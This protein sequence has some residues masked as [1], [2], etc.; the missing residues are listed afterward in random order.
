VDAVV[1]NKER[2]N[3]MFHCKLNLKK[4]V[5]V[6]LLIT[7]NL[8][9]VFPVWAKEQFNWKKFSGTEIRFLAGKHP[10]FNL[11]SKYI[12]E[13]EKLTGIKVKVENFPGTVST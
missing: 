4:A 8:T 13:F 7:L 9:A 10:W 1:I 3:I 5:I 12:P 11:V 2:V 6:L